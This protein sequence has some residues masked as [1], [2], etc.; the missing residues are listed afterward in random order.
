MGR[1]K[2][3]Y[4]RYNLKEID[5]EPA[6]ILGS[7]QWRREWIS[8]EYGTKETHYS[9]II[10]GLTMSGKLVQMGDGNGG[11]TGCVNNYRGGS[12]I[13]CGDPHRLLFFL[14]RAAQKLGVK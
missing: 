12:Y 7:L 8:P 10:T 4:G 9:E 14:R 6:Y 1:H 5:V 13:Y 11:W 2:D 3:Q